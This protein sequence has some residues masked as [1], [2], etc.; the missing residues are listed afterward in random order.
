MLV[1]IG[2]DPDKKE[3]ITNDPGTKNGGSYRYNEEVLYNAIWDYPTSEIDTVVPE[4][5][6]KAMLVIQKKDIE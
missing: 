4:K 2:Y 3:F 5:K 6:E 1:I